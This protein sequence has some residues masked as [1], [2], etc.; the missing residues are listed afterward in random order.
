MVWI[1]WVE[2]EFIQRLLGAGGMLTE[3]ATVLLSLR[4]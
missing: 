4:F 1:A 3:G 2:V